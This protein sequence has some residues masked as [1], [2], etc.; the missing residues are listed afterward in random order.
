MRSHSVLLKSPCL[1]HM[2]IFSQPNESTN[3]ARKGRSPNVEIRVLTNGFL[4]TLP[5]LVRILPMIVVLS[6]VT[7][8]YY[9]GYSYG[10]SQG[11]G[12]T[13]GWD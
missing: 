12:Y 3:W 2:H 10:Y 9:A 7:L 8:A 4:T 1:L 13:Q 6:L 11:W 5:P